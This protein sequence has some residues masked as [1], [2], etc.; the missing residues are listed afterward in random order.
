M[1]LAAVDLAKALGARMIAALASEKKRAV[2][3]TGYA[4][5]ALVNVTGGFRDQVFQ[6]TG[7]R[8]TYVIYDPVG[9][10]IIDES[11]RCV[12]FDG[13]LLTVGF[14]SGRLPVLKVNYALIKGFSVM[15]GRAG[16]A[17][18]S[19]NGGREPRG[20][21]AARREWPVKPRVDRE[22]PLAEWRKGF[23]TLAHRQVIGRTILR[24][25]L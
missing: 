8:G 21:L 4:P 17:G 14:I 16:T 7:G 1:D 3:E 23:E 22:F 13:R 11:V 18:D 2:I 9:G 19:L 5:N 10:D 12:A 15:G 24:P 25:D 6:I 20:H